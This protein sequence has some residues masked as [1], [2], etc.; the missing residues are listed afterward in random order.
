MKRSLEDLIKEVSDCS[1]EAKVIAARLES[2]TSSSDDPVPK[3]QAKIDTLVS[4][5]EDLRIEIRNSKIK[6]A[7]FTEEQAQIFRAKF[8]E[9]IKDL[10][11]AIIV[12]VYNK[13]WLEQL[14][15]NARPI[16]CSELYN[17]FVANDKTPPQLWSDII[18]SDGSM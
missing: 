11:V 9:S 4:T 8:R 5:I 13:A 10:G 12:S 7:E 18:H 2:S 1:Y 6:I 3:L 17:Y 16:V 15:V 14:P